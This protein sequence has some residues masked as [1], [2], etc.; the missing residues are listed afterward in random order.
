[1]PELETVRHQLPLLAISQ[2]QK[3]ITHNEALARID[4]LLHPVVEDE[5]SAPP[6]LSELDFGKCWL[7]G[8]LPT[9][10]W[11]GKPGQ[12]AIWAAGSWRFSTACEGMRIR[13][14][15][16]GLYLAYIDGQWVSPPVIPNPAGGA[17]IDVEARA[18]ITALLEHL[19]ALGF[20]T[21]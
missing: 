18:A 11:T 8:G 6:L 20:V 9:G 5:L 2:A 19:R 13:V 3:E 17:T 7:I 12:I 10:D 15:S 4:A 21:N 16:S 1:M 14:L